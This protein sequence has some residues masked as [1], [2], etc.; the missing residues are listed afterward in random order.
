MSAKN[1]TQVIIAGKIYTLSGYESEEYLQ[2][3]ASYLNG[4]ISEFKNMEGYSRLSPDL[5]SIM[6]DLNMA[7]DY[8]KMKK[9]I[10]E[11]EQELIAKEREIYDFKHDLITAQIRLENAQ[12]DVQTLEEKNIQL[13]KENIQMETQL[14][15]TSR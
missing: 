8:F 13:Q 5:K 15:N 3:V 6:L 14:K 12:K 2:R 1:K 10:E 4:K 7:D 11:L 9:K